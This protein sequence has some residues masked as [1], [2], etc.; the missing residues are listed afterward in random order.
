MKAENLVEMRGNFPLEPLNNFVLLTIQNLVPPIFP[1]AN[2]WNRAIE[3]R[4]PAGLKQKLEANFEP[5]GAHW[6]VSEMQSEEWAGL[7]L[8]LSVLLV[9]SVV[10]LLTSLVLSVRRDRF[11]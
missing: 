6:A 8:G 4:M 11:R 2:S 9:A 5:S 3:T 1:P 10:V 7:G